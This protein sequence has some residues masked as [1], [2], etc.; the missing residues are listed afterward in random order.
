MPINAR[1]DALGVLH[2]LVIRSIEQR[3]IF[4]DDEGKNNLLDINK[5]DLN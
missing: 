2:H 1:L 3:K 5:H 4:R